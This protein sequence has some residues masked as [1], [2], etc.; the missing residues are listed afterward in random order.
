MTKIKV[1]AKK[2]YIK[3]SSVVVKTVAKKRVNVTS[4]TL[5]VGFHNQNQWL[6]VRD[7]QK[8]IA[9]DGVTVDIATVTRACLVLSGRAGQ[10]VGVPPRTEF[11]VRSSN[12]RANGIEYKY[13]PEGTIRVRSTKNALG[14][15][16]YHQVA[17]ATFVN[18]RLPKSGV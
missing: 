13:N 16:T 8:E 7:I 4:L 17:K 12:R 3:T 1:R 9:K 5:F 6:T 11:L 14:N 15:V 18:K 10:L 2:K